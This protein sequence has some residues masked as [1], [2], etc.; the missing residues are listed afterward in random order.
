MTGRTPREAYFLIVVGVL[1]AVVGLFV[2]FSLGITL[3]FILAL[4]DPSEA[5]VGWLDVAGG[6]LFCS[7]GATAAAVLIKFY[8]VI[9]RRGAFEPPNR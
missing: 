7:I 2:L 8:R 6:L 1:I 5:E 9:E 4:L 3:S